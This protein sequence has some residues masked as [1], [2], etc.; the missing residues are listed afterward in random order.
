MINGFAQTNLQLLNQMQT[1]GYS[2]TEVS[3]IAKAYE[4]AMSLFATAF[5]ANGKPFLAHLVGTASVLAATE[6]PVDLI[7]AGLLHAA[8]MQGDFG[9]DSMATLGKK[10]QYLLKVLSPQAETYVARYTTL[11]WESK[12]LKTF[13][14]HPPDTLTEVDQSVLLVRLANEVEEYLDFGMV[15][16]SKYT[17]LAEHINDFGLLAAQLAK[18]MGRDDLEKLLLEQYEASMASKIDP[19][20]KSGSIASYIAVS[21]SYRKRFT[22]TALQKSTQIKSMTKMQ[23]RRVKHKLSRIL[24]SSL[25]TN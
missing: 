19:D 11:P 1:L 10:Q 12:S 20:L 2:A 15:Y 23:L 7:A 24:K 6:A 17:D 5:R 4:L 22:V 9:L 14:D 13:I 21:P 25:P 3:Y 8:Y 16:C 18:A